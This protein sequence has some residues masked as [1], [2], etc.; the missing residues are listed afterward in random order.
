[1]YLVWLAAVATALFFGFCAGRVT[2]G[3]TAEERVEEEKGRI[4]SG[5]SREKRDSGRGDARLAAGAVGSPV[6]GE[7]EDVQDGASPGVVIR[8]GE[9]KI[10]AP[11]SGKI[12][13]VFPLGNAFLFRTESG[14]ELHI[15]VGEGGDEL[16]GGYY[17]PRVLQN[18]IVSKGKLLLEF[19]RR[20]LEAEGIS[21]CVSVTVETGGC[22]SEMTA[23]A[24]ERVRTG[25]EILRIRRPGLAVSL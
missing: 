1:M 14:A 11:V 25:E 23:A 18:E 2:V 9:D 19:D 13:K 8:P 17:R 6:S 16:L 4:V 5:R 24:G 12:I 3:E 15:R 20:G 7:V 21:P 10:Y 22:G